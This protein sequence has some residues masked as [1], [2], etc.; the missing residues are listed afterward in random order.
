MNVGLTSFAVCGSVSTQMDLLVALFDDCDSKVEVVVS[1]YDRL[2]EKAELGK[3]LRS[4]P[5]DAQVI[6][7]PRAIKFTC[8]NFFLSGAELLTI[9]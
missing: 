6:M 8:F 4:L 9:Y 7:T 3:L 1:F 5:Q 2:A